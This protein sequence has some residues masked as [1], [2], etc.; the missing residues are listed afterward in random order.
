MKLFTIAVYRALSG[1]LLMAY[2]FLLCSLF[3]GSIVYEYE[4]E[5]QPEVF[6]S[7]LSGMWWGVITMGTVGFGDTIPIT[8]IG[9]TVGGVV[10]LCGPI[11]ISI[12]ISIIGAEAVRVYDEITSNEL[13]SILPLPNARFTRTHS[14]L[15]YQLLWG[16]RWRIQVW[17]FLTKPW[18]SDA[19][20]AMSLFVA[21]VVLLSLTCYVISSLPSMKSLAMGW[22]VIETAC[23]IF[24][25]IE[26]LLRWILVPERRSDGSTGI[27]LKMGKFGKILES[28][29]RFLLRPFTIIDLFSIVP[30]YLTHWS[31]IRVVR[32]T[33][34]VRIFKL[35]RHSK[36]IDV[37][38][39]AFQLGLPAALM[40]VGFVVMSLFVLGAVVFE[41]EKDE[42]ETEFSSI[43]ASFWLIT[44]TITTV[45]YG[46]MVPTTT[47]GKCVIAIATIVG[48]IGT[49]L[50]LTVLGTYFSILNNQNIRKSSVIA[51]RDRF[52]DEQATKILNMV[53]DQISG[54]RHDYPNFDILIRVQ[55]RPLTLSTRTAREPQ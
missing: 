29:L 8:P 17:N 22:N 6:K 16:S 10:M 31:T 49:T 39:H 52:N 28:R 3:W 24:L 25:T 48:I 18:G 38:L 33:R 35:G 21:G 2:L 1:L 7:A 15:K 53:R 44:Q 13:D 34:L 27:W 50:P 45:G 14:T 30:F 41:F 20:R 40:F 37:L 55:K 11:L 4:T 43:P 47:G 51:R 23:V 12:P 42:P 9:R 46:D 26:F 36:T 19:A 5:A 32:L 54:I